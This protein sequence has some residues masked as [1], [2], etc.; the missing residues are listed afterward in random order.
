MS[1]GLNPISFQTSALPVISLLLAGVVI[2]IN[3]AIDPVVESSA[4]IAHGKLHNTGS[5]DFVTPDACNG[6]G[7]CSV[8][9]RPAVC[10]AIIDVAI[11]SS[12]PLY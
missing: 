5:V 9:I 8:G 7:I 12:V 10:V 6:I 3:V 2:G 11:H 1:K 4:H